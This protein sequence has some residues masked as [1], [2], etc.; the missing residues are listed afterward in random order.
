M[1]TGGISIAS[2]AWNSLVLA[3]L[4]ITRP[5]SDFPVIN[6]YSDA[7]PG[8][9]EEEARKITNP[10]AEESADKSIKETDA[11]MKI[12]DEFQKKYKKSFVRKECLRHEIKTI[13]ANH[14]VEDGEKLELWEAGSED[15]SNQVR[16]E[17][18]TEFI[19]RTVEKY[20]K[21]VL[22]VIS[23]SDITK[24]CIDVEA[25]GDEDDLWYSVFEKYDFDQT[26]DSC[27]YFIK[28]GTATKIG[29]TDSLNA[30]FSQ[31]KT[32]AALP[33]E[34]VNVVYTHF[35]YR[36]EQKL[37]RC[38]S[39]F[40]SHL[41]WFILPSEIEEILFKAKSCKDIEDFLTWFED[42]Y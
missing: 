5:A 14:I 20:G 27:L 9:T 31:I 25:G 38:L 7:T 42:K 11:W 17:I 37:H 18:R 26:T 40:N 13:I 22:S 29:I 34:I 39:Q 32:S 2:F 1:N 21:D 35:G 19:T 8:Y 4:E 3:Y 6:I 30:R 16:A 28:Q 15:R 23:P 33:C 24:Y 10:T 41:E 36:V 12:R